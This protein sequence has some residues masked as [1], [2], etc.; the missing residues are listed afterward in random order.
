MEVEPEILNVDAV[1]GN[2]YDER[3]NDSYYR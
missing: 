3:F 2:I 1:L